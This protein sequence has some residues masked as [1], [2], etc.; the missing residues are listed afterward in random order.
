LE[1]HPRRWTTDRTRDGRRRRR[2]VLLLPALAIAAV[3]LIAGCGGSA[4]SSATTPPEGIAGGAPVPSSLRSPS[5][6]TLHDQSG[7]PVSLTGERGHPVVVTF[8]YVHCP[9]VCPLIAEHLGDALRELPAP[10]RS[11]A[12]VLAVSVDPKGDTAPAVR[13]FIAVHRLPAQF[14][15]LTGTM[16]QLAPI[17]KA[18]DV[19]AVPNATMDQIDHS[20]YELFIDPQG[21]ARVIFGSDMTPRQAARALTEIAS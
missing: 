2:A 13:H 19:S 1:E 3:A 9:D 8:L 15:Y 16:T 4:S 10:V 12:R 21:H 7:A 5:D 17:W 20:A 14:R 6:F 18:Y 11:R